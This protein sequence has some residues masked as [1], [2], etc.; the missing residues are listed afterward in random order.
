MSKKYNNLALTIIVVFTML[1]MAV[2][3]AGRKVVRENP[4][5][6]I[7]L[8]G[9]WNDGD[10]RRVSEAMIKDCL[11]AAWLDKFTSSQNG[12]QPDVIV[13]KVKNK[14]H[15]H[16][17]VETFIKDLERTLINAGKVSFV[18]SGS[19]RLDIREE[20]K[21][22]ARH[23]SEESQKAPGQEAGADFMLTGSVNSIVDSIQSEKVVFYQI[24]LELI[25][26][27]N[28]RKVWIGEK[29]IKKYI[30]NPSVTY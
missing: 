9:R 26:M 18:A 21:D 22:Q 27:A 30:E 13:G 6:D 16:I 8:S 14:S 3:C 11:S 25:D 2:G 28:N 20:R 7:D 15:E 12:K 5:K 19:E 10:S 24:N 1:L 29:K 4:N 23:S 17:A